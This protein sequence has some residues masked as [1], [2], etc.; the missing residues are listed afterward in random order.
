MDRHYRRILLATFLASLA[1][2]GSETG[3]TE[4]AIGD[5]PLADKG[6]AKGH[7]PSPSAKVTLEVSGCDFTVTY[8]WRRFEGT[9]MVARFELVVNGTA[10]RQE[11]VGDH[12][13]RSGTESYTFH[14]TETGVSRDIVATGSLVESDFHWLVIGTSGVASD[15]VTSTCG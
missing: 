4:S 3:I 12:L 8:T 7:I 5:S 11:F 14:L 1:A 6:A 13:N 10:I 15:P 2:C 9:N